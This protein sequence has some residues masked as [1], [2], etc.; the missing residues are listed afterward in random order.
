VVIDLNRDGELRYGQVTM[1]V[2]GDGLLDVTKWAGAQD[3]VL[4]W[5]KFAD[6]LVHDNSQYAFA[7]YATTYRMDALGQ[8]RSATDLEGLADAFDSN[9]DGVF[10]AQDAQFAEFKVWQDANQNGVSDAGEVRSLVDWGI[11]SIN[12]LSDG[13]ARTPAAGVIEAGQTLAMAADGTS[14]LVADAAFA[15]SAMDYRIGGGELS[16]QGSQ[17]KLHLSSLVSQHGAIDHV[18]LNGSGAN[19][20]QISLQDVLLG[21]ASGRLRVTGN[22]DDNVQLDANAWTNSGR[23]VFENGHRYAVFNAN[24][25]VAAQLLLDKQLLC[26]VL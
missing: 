1:D 26:H 11:S 15:Y 17:M 7:Q 25:D 5:D 23:V 6:G 8:A 12:L 9:R 13:V 10:D 24:Q 18:D 3:G 21:S 2:N 4:V 19:T 22:A 20:L 14:V 16:L